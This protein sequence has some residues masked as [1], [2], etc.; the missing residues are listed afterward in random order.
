MRLDGETRCC[1]VIQGFQ[2][3][4]GVWIPKVLPFVCGIKAA[5]NIVWFNISHNTILERNKS[6]NW[7]WG[8]TV[9]TRAYFTN[10]LTDIYA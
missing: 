2:Q 9:W 10:E 7:S 4:D 8:E 5:T 3:I 6:R 1:L